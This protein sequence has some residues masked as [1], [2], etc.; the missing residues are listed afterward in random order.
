[1]I[2]DLENL[3]IFIYKNGKYYCTG[4]DF[5]ITL[6]AVELHKKLLYENTKRNIC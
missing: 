3:G 1:M 5:T 2:E 4:M 6:K